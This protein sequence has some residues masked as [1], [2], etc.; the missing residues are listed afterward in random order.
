MERENL[1]TWL[2]GDEAAVRFVEDVAYVTQVWDDLID[3]DKPVSD[4]QINGAFERLFIAVPRNSF[5]RT[6]FAELQPL[7]EQMIVDWHTANALERGT[8][9]DRM[10]AW[11]LRDSLTA[12]VIRAAILIGGY[13]WGLECAPQI[14]RFVHDEPFE[15]YREGLANG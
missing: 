4:D 6:Y 9:Q 11:M 2:R 7:V 1:L 8:T 14:R 15:E 10:A 3:R 12:V 13:A 5:Y